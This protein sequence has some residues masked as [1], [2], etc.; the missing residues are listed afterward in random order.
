MSGCLSWREIEALADGAGDASAREHAARC[1]RCG[2][3]LAAEMRYREAARSLG[4]DSVPG[5]PEAVLVAVATAKPA[6]PLSCRHV[7]R[8]L[9]L[10][11]DGRL[12]AKAVMDFETHLFTCRSCYVAYRQALELRDGLSSLTEAPPDGLLEQ[13]LSSVAA[14][15]PVA[16]PARRGQVATVRALAAAAAVVL[17]IGAAL[18][19]R[20]PAPRPSSVTWPPGMAAAQT[21]RLSPSLPPE[22]TFAPA[23]STVTA[24]APARMA[25]RAGRLRGERSARPTVAAQTG[26]SKA[27]PSPVAQPPVLASAQPSV[28][29]RPV[30]AA[31]QVLEPSRM[32]LA[33]G[34]TIDSPARAPSPAPAPAPTFPVPS[35]AIT[36]ASAPV[37]TAA[38]A[39]PSSAG[40]TAHP[41]PIPAPAQPLRLAEATT[42]ITPRWLPVREGPTEHIS[43]APAAS[44]T[45]LEA[46]AA[47]VNEQL[48]RDDLIHRSG[49]IPLK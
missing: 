1:A 34:L 10:Y 6:R 18:W 23:S 39:P 33:A 37:S 40:A 46:V 45:P 11:L 38:P 22:K 8:L 41:E 44:Q 26:S 28:P 42:D 2:R 3:R 43:P 14:A 9:D 31:A 27:P 20:Q 30:A 24:P 16:S 48:R 7:R 25:A 32:V 49:W 5:V 47:R 21:P 12:P 36:D 35:A 15:S 29:D 17:L 13:V 4:G 19:M